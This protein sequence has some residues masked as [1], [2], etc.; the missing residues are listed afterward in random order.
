MRN[1]FTNSRDVAWNGSTWQ[2]VPNRFYT[3]E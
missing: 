3:E 2:Y 1:N